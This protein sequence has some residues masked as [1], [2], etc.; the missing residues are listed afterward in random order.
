MSQEQ[1][2][3]FLLNVGWVVLNDPELK[4][5][6]DASYE[7]ALQKQN[8]RTCS[9]KG[10]NMHRYYVIR[11]KLEKGRTECGPF[12]EGEIPGLAMR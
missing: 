8:T 5:P 11:H 9:D 6:Y 10:S 3:K 4:G 12:K 2:M 1:Q 7:R